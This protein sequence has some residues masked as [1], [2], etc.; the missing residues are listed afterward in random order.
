MFRMDAS[1]KWYRCLLRAPTLLSG[2][3]WASFTNLS[4]WTGRQHTQNAWQQVFYAFHIV[5]FGIGVAN[6]NSWQVMPPSRAHHAP[7]ARSELTSRPM[8][9]LC[10]H[11]GKIALFKVSASEAT[12][13]FHLTI[14]ILFFRNSRKQATKMQ[15]YRTQ[16]AA[17]STDAQQHKP[18]LW[19]GSP[20]HNEAVFA[21]T[22][23]GGGSGSLSKHQAMPWERGLPTSP[24]GKGTPVFHVESCHTMQLREKL[25]VVWSVRQF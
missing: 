7:L 11:V 16:L 9:R 20:V 18:I 5:R 4:R 1:D 2:A 25:H 24:Q 14:W 3:S 15:N 13:R 23:K 8:Q 6:T 19:S 10:S 21:A 12:F 22:A 17:V